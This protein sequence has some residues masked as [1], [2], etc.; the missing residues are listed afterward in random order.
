MSSPLQNLCPDP[1]PRPVFS[2]TSIACPLYVPPSA[3][4][5]LPSDQQA[6]QKGHISKPDKE[7]DSNGL[8]IHLY[9]STKTANTTQGTFLEELLSVGIVYVLFCT[10]IYL[11]FPKYGPGVNYFQMASDQALN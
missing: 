2:H 11:I 6:R 10:F 4:E 1:D 3:Q 9:N 5:E 7:P 8:S